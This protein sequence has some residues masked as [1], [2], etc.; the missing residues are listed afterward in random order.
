L[1]H[2]FSNARGNDKV[3]SIPEAFLAL[4][5]FIAAHSQEFQ[6]RFSHENKDQDRVHDSEPQ[7]HLN[8]FTAPVGFMSLMLNV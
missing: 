4:P 2:N 6:D 8:I 5:A 1:W 3:K 7:W